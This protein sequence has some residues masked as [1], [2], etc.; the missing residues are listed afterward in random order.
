MAA[1]TLYRPLLI[2]GSSYQRECAFSV[3][4]YTTSEVSTNH[5][6]INYKATCFHLP[7]NGTEAIGNSVCEDSTFPPCLH[8][9]FITQPRHIQLP[10]FISQDS[11]ESQNLQVVS[12]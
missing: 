2:L 12:R 4:N 3:P 11:L 10:K 6:G 7:D 1:V 5:A 8:T 9:A